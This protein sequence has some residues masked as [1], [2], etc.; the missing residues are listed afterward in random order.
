MYDRTMQIVSY[1]VCPILIQEKRLL[2]GIT[3]R[4]T[5][6][7]LINEINNLGFRTGPTQTGL[8]SHRRKL[9]LINEPVYEKTNNLGV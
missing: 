3:F 4:S 2:H 8:Y 6:L 9:D 5:S 1:S 7:D